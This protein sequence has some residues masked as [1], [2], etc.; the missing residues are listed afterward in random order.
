QSKDGKSPLHMTAVHG[1]FTRSQ[2]LIQNGGEIDCVDKDGNTPLHVAARYGHELLINTLITSGADTA[3]CGIHNMFP[4]HLAALN[5]HSD[6]CRKLLSSGQKYSIVSLFSNERVLSAGFDIDTPDSFGR[7]CLHAAAAGGCAVVP[8][9]LQPWSP[10]VVHLPPS[11][12]SSAVLKVTKRK[13]NKPKQQQKKPTKTKPPS[14]KL[15][16]EKAVPLSGSCIPE[17]WCLEF[18]LQNDANPSIQ[19]KEGYNTVH[20]AAAYGHRQCLELV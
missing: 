8:I 17:K 15:E 16:S 11:H 19:D 14:S 13:P 4:L 1:R 10:N 7:T 18:L 9:R 5:A 20:Y 12:F 6:C 2:T 3:K